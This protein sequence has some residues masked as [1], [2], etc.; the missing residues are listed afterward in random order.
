MCVKT[1]APLLRNSNLWDGQANL[2]SEGYNSV[3]KPECLYTAEHLVLNTK[4]KLMELN[5]KERKVL[6]KM[7]GLKKIWT[8]RWKRSN[9]KL[10]VQN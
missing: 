3:I 5:K 10:Y 1:G 2:Y 4:G 8:E 7:Y 6:K 9:K